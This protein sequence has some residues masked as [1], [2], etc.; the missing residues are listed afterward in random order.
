MAALYLASTLPTALVV[1]PNA[2][3]LQ[4]PTH[5]FA[6]TTMA[7]DDKAEVMEYFNN[8]GFNRWSRIYSEDGEVNKV[9]LDIRTGHGQ[10]VDKVLRWVDADGSA[11]DGAT[12]CDAGCGVGSLALPLA[13]RGAQV[14]ASDI[15]D[16][17]VS[18][19]TSRAAAAGLSERVSF[20][21]SDLEN[22][23][24][25]FDTVSCIDVMIHYPSDKMVGMV[26]HLAGLAEKRLIISF[27]PNTWYY[28]AL[29]SF[30]ELFPGPS[31]TT[32]AYLHTEEAVL[33]AL[34]VAGFKPERTEMTGT[35]FY[36]SR[37]IEAVRE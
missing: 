28:R 16:A 32:R 12:F 11:K 2:L 17:M 6:L 37:L 22:L 34:R 3:V 18:E 7:V 20:S 33:D 10:T 35:N 4:S 1:T 29:K 23:S 9:Q 15:S 19:A 25:S 13:D 24:G 5:R 21:T 8:E 26:G 14:T 27:A 31:K 30:G 36:F